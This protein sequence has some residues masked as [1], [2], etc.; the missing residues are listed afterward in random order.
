MGTHWTCYFDNGQNN[1]HIYINLDMLEENK[2]VSLKKAAE[3]QQ[4]VARYYNQNICVRQFNTR[5]QVLRRINQAIRDSNQRVSSPNWEGLYR[6]LR[7]AGLETYI[8]AY[9]DR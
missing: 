8:L 3:Y 7:V 9:P 5:D 2:R 4:K 6:V 1:K